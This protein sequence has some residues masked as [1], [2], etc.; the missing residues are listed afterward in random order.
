[1]QKETK[2]SIVVKIVGILLGSSGLIV[3]GLNKVKLAIIIEFVVCVYV[4]IV[5]F[6]NKR[7]EQK[8]TEKVTIENKTKKE[9]YARILRKYWIHIW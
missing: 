8:Y 2:T 1:M 4:L 3:A 7:K 6:I 5:E 9:L